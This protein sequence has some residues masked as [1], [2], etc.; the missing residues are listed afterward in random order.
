[1]KSTII[2]ALVCFK[3]FPHLELQV[4][5]SKQKMYGLKMQAGALIHMPS[6]V[7]MQQ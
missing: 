6:M 1:M 4:E 5:H 7:I 2:I 3:V